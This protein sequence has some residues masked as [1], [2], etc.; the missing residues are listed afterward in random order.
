[1]PQTYH[2]Q[3]T[4]YHIEKGLILC[5]TIGDAGSFICDAALYRPL[6]PGTRVQCSCVVGG[7]YS[8]TRWIFTSF[9]GLQFCLHNFIELL[10]P[11][12]CLPPI[13]GSVGSC[14]G[15]LTAANRD[16]GQGLPCSTSTL[17]ISAHTVLNGLHIE[18]RDMSQE[19]FGILVGNSSI[20][21]VGEQ[22]FIQY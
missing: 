9:S 11:P 22:F 4:I 6:C 18:C 12:P 7:S 21:I 17:T 10:Q 19:E 2:H 16:P 3:Y 13:I 8:I 14:G 15:Y 20:I 1:M 5:F